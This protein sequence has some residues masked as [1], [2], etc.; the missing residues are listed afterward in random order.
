MAKNRNKLEDFNLHPKQTECWDYLEDNQ[1]T[2]VLYGGGAGGGKSVLISYWQWYRRM[3]MPRSRGV[4]GRKKL[5]TLKESTLKT[6]FDVC[7]ALG[8]KYRLGKYYRYNDKYS[9]IT[10]NNGSEIYLKDLFL[11]PTDPEFDDLGSTEYTDGAID[12]CNQV[13]EK[14]RN[15][16]TTRLRYKL[17]EFNTIP[18]LLLSCN[19]AKG[20][21]YNDYYLPWTKQELLDYRRFVPAIHSDNPDLPKAYV[22]NLKRLPDAATKARL[23]E[24]LWDFDDD[25][26]K[27]FRY[28]DIQSLYD[29]EHIATDEELKNWKLDDRFITCDVAR[30][31]KDKTIILVW[32]GFTV[33]E[34]IVREKLRNPDV[35]SLI[36]SKMREYGISIK[37]VCVDEDGVGG[38]VVDLLRGCVGFLN[39]SKPIVMFDGHILNYA[40]LK[41]QCYHLLAEYVRE[42][43]MWVSNMQTHHQEML[44]QELDV[45]RQHKGDQDGKISVEPKEMIKQKIGRSPDFADALMMRMRFLLNMYEARIVVG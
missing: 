10:F 6:F 29:N 12:E 28:E 17:D 34:T 43:K 37:N 2:E 36:K 9:L 8:N 31:G 33:V 4:I 40:N 5:K 11:Y 21:V 35:A 42:C 41:S 25:L 18:K 20:Y 30:L 26:F 24:G 23:L 7:D 38:G 45:V 32:K 14:A 1:T 15:V 39:N 19:P 27:W 16:L 3:T 13:V 44:S 22:E